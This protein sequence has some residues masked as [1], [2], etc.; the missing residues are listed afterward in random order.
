[1]TIPLLWEI[2]LSL[3]CILIGMMIFGSIILFIKAK[4]NSKDLGSR[5]LYG[6][7]VAFFFLS[8]GIG[9]IVRMYFMFFLATTPDE[10]ITQTTATFRNSLAL[11]AYANDGRL[12][13]LQ[14]L[15]VLHMVIVFIGIG[16]LL[17]A[18]EYKIYKKTKYTFTIITF[19]ILPVI[20]LLP[21]EIAQNLFYISYLSPLAWMVIYISVAAKATGSVRKN[22]IMLLVGF[23]IFVVGI[24]FNS[25]TVRRLVFGTATGEYHVGDIGAIFSIWIAPV[26]LTIGFS[27]MLLAMLNKF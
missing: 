13:L 20:I 15:W 8:I 18:T 4:K 26:M 7:C 11:P 10:F 2:G 23:S 27:L 12:E 16:L 1:M 17:F 5:D 21:F 6:L 24:L 25:G 14:N 22:A 3:F 9:Y 19:A